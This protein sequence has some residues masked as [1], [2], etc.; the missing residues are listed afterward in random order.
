MKCDFNVFS[1]GFRSSIT[2]KEIDDLKNAKQHFSDCYIMTSLET[3]SHTPNGRKILKEHIEHDDNKPNIINCYLYKANGEKEKFAV[4]S[5]IVVEGYEKLYKSQPNDIVRSMDISVAEYEKKYK[6]KPWIC[7]VTGR[8]KTYE[9]ENN[10]P[11]HFLKTLTGIEPTVNI[12]ETDFNID[13]TSKK[14]EVLKLFKRMQSEP[15]YSLL[16]GTGVK[17]LDGRTFHVYMIE[18]VDLENNKIYY[19]EKRSNTPKEMDIDTALKSFK[20]IVGYFNKDLEKTQTKEN[21]A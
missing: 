5:D 20:Y 17:K 2:D 16:I 19:K 14:S 3:L 12:A 18:K 7:R 1:L 10:L 8:F 21:P 4:P 13:L 9:F 11:S 15:D 6:A